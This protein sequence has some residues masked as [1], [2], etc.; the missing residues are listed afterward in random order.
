MNIHSVLKAATGALLL[1]GLAG[2]AHAAAITGSSANVQVVVAPADVS[3]GGPLESNSF[4]TVFEEQT[5]ALSGYGA[6]TVTVGEN[7]LTA[8]GGSI[9]GTVTSFFVHFDPEVDT[10][11][12]G[13]FLE[14]DGPIVGILWSSL[15]T[16]DGVFGLPGTAY[17]PASTRGYESA[18][19]LVFTS[20]NR[21]DFTAIVAGN[22]VDSFRVLIGATAVPEP[23]AL[24]VFGLG[25]ALLGFA[26]RRRTA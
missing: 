5:V 8:T 11:L 18:D 26:R 14:F 1:I 3:G 16:S 19:T 6:N 2:T 9:T 12:S 13:G 17:T 22:N 10:T 25:L 24:A 15:G 23:G 7:L 20:A 21:V 4:F